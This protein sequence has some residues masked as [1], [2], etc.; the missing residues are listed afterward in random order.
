MLNNNE[1]KLH[2]VR[3]WSLLRNV[4]QIMTTCVFVFLCKMKH[5]FTVR[6]FVFDQ[7]EW[8]AHLLF[9][10][11]GGPSGAIRSHFSPH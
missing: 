2:D 6:P 1:A 8:P 9:G 5:P 10:A 7:V 3:V 11:T 4:E